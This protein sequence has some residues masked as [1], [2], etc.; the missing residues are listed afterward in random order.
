[1]Q[2]LLSSPNTRTKSGLKCFNYHYQLKS[3]REK[4]QQEVEQTNK[5]CLCS[6]NVTKHLWENHYL[7]WWFVLVS[8]LLRCFLT[9]KHFTNDSILFTGK[10]CETKNF[11]WNEVRRHFFLLFNC[12]GQVFVEIITRISF[13]TVRDWDILG[14]HEEL[15]NGFCGNKIQ[16]AYPLQN[17]KEWN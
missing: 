11:V 7:V 12:A 14:W 8:V 5:N 9:G 10:Q 15:Y 6:K 1:M 16:Q 4:P 2:S 13:K 3:D 17:R